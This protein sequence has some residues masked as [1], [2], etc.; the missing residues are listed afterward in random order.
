[1]ALPRII[2]SLGVNPFVE[3]YGFAESD[4]KGVCIKSSWRPSR[5]FNQGN[6]ITRCIFLLHKF[7]ENI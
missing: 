4:R 7:Q 1:M 3:E 2:A 6:I 5:F